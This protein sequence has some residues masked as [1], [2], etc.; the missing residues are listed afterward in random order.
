[1]HFCHPSSNL[2]CPVSHSSGAVCHDDP[3]EPV[4]S[5][6]GDLLPATE[7]H[8]LQ[9]RRLTQT[10]SNGRRRFWHQTLQHSGCFD[11]TSDSFWDFVGFFL[12]WAKISQ[13]FP[14]RMTQKLFLFYFIPKQ[15]LKSL[16]KPSV[17]TIC[18]VKADFSLKKKKTTILSPKGTSTR[19]LL[20]LSTSSSSS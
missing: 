3:A 19:L 2:F 6:H 1:M 14:L 16:N 9:E 13:I 17:F 18:D 10:G 4:G 7:R 20:K 8:K 12:K 11:P 5:A 15:V